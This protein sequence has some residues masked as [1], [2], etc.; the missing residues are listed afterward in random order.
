MDALLHGNT[1]SQADACISDLNAVA[2]A[3]RVSGGEVDALGGRR[4]A[5]RLDMLNYPPQMSTYPYRMPR[6]RDVCLD[7][8]PKCKL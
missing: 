1:K 8:P 5:A 2:L 4:E 3:L 7:S 6:C